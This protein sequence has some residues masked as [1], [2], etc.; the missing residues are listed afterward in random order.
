[1]RSVRRSNLDRAAGPGSCYSWGLVPLCYTIEAVCRGGL[2]A[3]PRLR[4]AVNAL[5][6]AQDQSGGWCRNPGG[7]FSCTIRA[8]RAVGAHPELRAGREAEAALHYLRAHQSRSGSRAGSR[9][10][11]SN[12]F[13]ALH[14]TARFGLP[15]AKEIIVDALSVVAQQQRR[16][17]TFGTPLP[18]ERVAAVIAASRTLES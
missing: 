15:V 7:G 2:H 10:R 16:N 14:A 5:L 17:G 1:V 4:P 13:S 6:G 9:W 18:I 12:L 8:I 11:G 3:D